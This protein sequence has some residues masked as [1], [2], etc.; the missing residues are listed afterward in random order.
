M[1]GFKPKRDK[2]GYS[3]TN[4]TKTRLET[5]DEI[6]EQIDLYVEKAEGT[7][8]IMSSTIRDVLTKKFHI[9]SIDAEGTH[10]KMPDQRVMD[11]CYALRREYD[12][13]PSIRA[14]YPDRGRINVERQNTHYHSRREVIEATGQNVQNNRP[15]ITRLR[16]EHATDDIR[17]LKLKDRI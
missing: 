12:E 4:L 10:R 6:D 15:R 16:N 7:G 11:R 3:T 2:S 8:M 9:I 14:D 5:D 17:V 13:Q 1:R